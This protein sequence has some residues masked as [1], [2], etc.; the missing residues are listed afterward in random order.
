VDYL[1]ACSEHIN[2]MRVS[3]ANAHHASDT[4]GQPQKLLIG[5]LTMP[6]TSP[7]KGRQWIA[8]KIRED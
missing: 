6:H 5:D 3:L 2:A 7:R 8:T 4:M 1:I